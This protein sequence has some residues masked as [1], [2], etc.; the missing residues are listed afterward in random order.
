MI[1]CEAREDGCDVKLAGTEVNLL[2]EFATIATGMR[3]QFGLD[4]LIAALVA[5]S[6]CST[7]VDSIDLSVA[8]SLIN[9]LNANEE[10][11]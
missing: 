4:K 7:S 5:L 9:Q 3:D 2:L 8:S 10:M 1:H 6:E 11:G